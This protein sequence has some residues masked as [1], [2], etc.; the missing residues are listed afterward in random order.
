MEYTDIIFFREKILEE[1]DR[2]PEF[3]RMMTTTSG[4]EMKV[5]MPALVEIPALDP[6]D[7][8]SDSEDDS[9]STTGSNRTDQQ[10]G[11]QMKPEA[12]VIYP[13][14]DTSNPQS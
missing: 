14:S 3:A 13:M 6:I 7:L 10:D 9:S 4:L 5:S 8:M 11:S 1:I 12:K 2:D